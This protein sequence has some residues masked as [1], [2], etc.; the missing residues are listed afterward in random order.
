[1]DEDLSSLTITE[2]KDIVSDMHK[3]ATN[4]FGLL[5]NLLEWSQMQQGVSNFASMPI[6]LLPFV[7]GIVQPIAEAANNKKL[8]FSFD[9][10]EGLEV[11][12]DKNMLASTLR[13]LCSNS[14]K[15]TPSG[16]Y[17]SI[18]AFAIGNGAVEIAVKDNG[19]GMNQEMVGKMFK[20]D[21]NISR[22]GTNDEPSTGLGLLL[23]KEF[24]EKNNGKI[25]VESSV[26]IGTTFYISLPS[27][28]GSVQGQ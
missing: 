6:V 11:S 26:G 15:F 5:Q 22:K 12:V 14:V 17:I 9:I 13:N 27:V 24:I 2:I 1:M 3:S 7:T 23:C 20:L 8:C 19:I 18:S 28:V 21:K 10:P 4:L 16:G 25:W